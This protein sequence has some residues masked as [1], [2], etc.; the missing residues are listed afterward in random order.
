MKL[1]PITTATMTSMTKRHM[2][3]RLVW[4]LGRISAKNEEEEKEEEDAIRWYIR[5]RK[6]RPDRQTDMYS[7]WFDSSRRSPDQTKDARMIMVPP[8]GFQ[9]GDFL[10]F[11]E[12]I[13]T[14]KEP[15][16]SRKSTQVFPLNIAIGMQRRPV[17]AKVIQCQIFHVS[18]TFTLGGIIFVETYFVSPQL[19]SLAESFL[20][21]LTSNE[22]N[23]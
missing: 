5:L 16:V 23:F 9:I 7:Y 8:L 19:L 3:A 13:S 22:H 15:S 10:H 18:S 12:I 21:K 6:G 4:T 1:M 20:W 2:A 14:T 11:R 17:H